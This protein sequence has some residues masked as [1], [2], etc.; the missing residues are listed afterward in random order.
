VNDLSGTSVTSV[1]V[2]LGQDDNQADLVVVNGT[3]AADR[4]Q[5]ANDGGKTR[6]SGLAAAV[7]VS[8]EEPADAVQVNGGDGADTATVSA[9]DDGDRIQIAAAAPLVDVPAP[10][11]G[12]RVPRT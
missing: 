12:V 7:E 1:N 2:D 8:N 9:S 10:V 3:N 5:V 4:V 11:R 6:V